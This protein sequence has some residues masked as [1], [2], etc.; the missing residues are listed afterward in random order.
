MLGR[1]SQEVFVIFC[2][3]NNAM[4]VIK[5]AFVID[6][7]FIVEYNIIIAIYIPAI[8]TYEKFPVSQFVNI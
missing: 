2:G 7:E 5:K 8:I 3:W 1:L 4:L 6:Q